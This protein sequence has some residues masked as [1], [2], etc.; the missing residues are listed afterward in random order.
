MGLEST[1]VVS[2]IFG[3]F[4]YHRTYSIIFDGLEWAKCVKKGLLQHS[5]NVLITTI[6]IYA[7]L[8]VLKFIIPK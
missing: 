8:I 3:G 7:H 5:L 6:I 1:L 2:F 4:C